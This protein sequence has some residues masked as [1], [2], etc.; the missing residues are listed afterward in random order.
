MGRGDVCSPFSPRAR[1]AN[2]H[3]EAVG[4]AMPTAS[5]LLPYRARKREA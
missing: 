5:G 4:C 2:Q 3:T 1:N